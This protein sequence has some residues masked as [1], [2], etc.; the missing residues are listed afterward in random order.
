MR[1][2]LTLVTLIAILGSASFFLFFHGQSNNALVKFVRLAKQGRLIDESIAKV[3]R[4]YQDFLDSF[5]YAHIQS[6]DW[7]VES[8][9]DR[10]KLPEYKWIRAATPAELTPANG[11]PDAT[12]YA[13]WHRSHGDLTSSRYSSLHQINRDNVANL[14]VAWTHRSGG[15]KGDVQC[16]PAIADG[17]LFTASSGH[18]I[19]ALNAETGKEVWK[20]DPG[21][22]FPA[23]RGIVWWPGTAEIK[24]RIYFPAGDRLFALDA[25]T[26]R[27]SAGFGGGSVK[28]GFEGRIAPAIA[29]GVI[30]HAS[31][32][33][34]VH[35]FDVVTG[36]LL[37]STSLLAKDKPPGPGGRPSKLAGGHPW[38]GMALDE[39]RG[40]AYLTTGNPRPTLVGV[41]RP[42]N[43]LHS[44]SVIA[45]NIHTGAILWTF[46]EVPHDLW[47][48]DL[49]APPVL[50]TIERSG[51]RF[52]VVVAV[53]KVGNTLL[54]DRMSGKPIFDFRMRRVPT[55]K[56]P[57]ER[58]APY[59]PDV[60]LP[61][62]F[63]RQRFDRS[64][65]TDIG[66]ANKQSV[67]DQLANKNL[68]FFVPHEEG[69]ETV[70]FG[71]NGGAEW[72]GAAAD[73]GTGMLYVA[74]NHAP[75]MTTV[76]NA[77][78]ELDEAGLPTTPGRRV[79]LDRCATCHGESREG[80]AG[81]PLLRLN[82]QHL[83]KE[84]EAIV[85]NG[86]QAMPAVP[87]ISD[88]EMYALLE[89]LF[90]RDRI[91]R[92]KVHESRRSGDYRF[93]KAPYRKLLD[94]EHYPG[95]KPP[96]GTLNAIDLNSGRIA[97]R[98]PL[99]EFRELT[100]R[101]IPIT[102]T[103]N[104]SGPVV[105]AGGLI[106]VSGT[107]DK[108]IRAFDSETGSELWRHELPFVG[109]APPATYQINGRQYVV[110]SATGSRSLRRY[111]KSIAIGDA[112]VAFAL[113]K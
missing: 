1:I 91:V 34:A 4:T 96:W 9:E 89:Y 55:S 103:E 2:R 47:D 29:K 97:W 11:R 66:K 24:P 18:H 41:Y 8:S 64:D 19:V 112:F 30:V 5:I 81:P 7:E 58:T 44:N 108:M 107:M 49:P 109:S 74:S 98:V 54:L 70:Y 92:Q 87:G 32:E 113:P 60:E 22:K 61:E 80:A 100:A 39:T 37:W 85:R 42:G 21:F 3:E 50:T 111:S 14:R 20:F 38:G 101:G 69:V 15:G 28:V 57:G 65:V 31:L 53:T 13:D 93:V 73:P 76:I 12:A 83:S 95:S 10:E 17:L 63:A 27:P 94:H 51:Q 68:G 48:L 72:P 43:N 56:L 67:L 105:T 102:G 6:E 77:D 23:K 59:Q 106:F 71:V 99:G 45:I 46:Q 36:K 25:S 62:P 90:T 35:G 75:W 16:N 40:I 104:R 26:G 88:D 84:V 33:P 78:G 110:I 79:Y 82:L 52:D 86:Q